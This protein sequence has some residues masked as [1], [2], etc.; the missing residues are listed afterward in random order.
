MIA[1][2]Q[3]ATWPIPLPAT[4]LAG[5][6]V[7]LELLN[8]SHIPELAAAGR[9]PSVWEFTTSRGVTD[10]GMQSY[11]ES[12][13]RDWERGAAVPFAVRQNSSGNIVGC[14]RV[15]E[16]NRR[17]RHGTVGSWYAPEAWRTGANLEAKLLVLDYAF[18]ELGC[19]RVE[20]H[21]DTRNLRSRTS[22]E[23]V[24]AVLE[25]VLRAHQITRDDG[26]RDSAIYSILR[27]EWEAVRAGIDARLERYRG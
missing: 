22:L 24:G 14:T 10:A 21:T 6:L 20:F 27:T 3:P 4:T 25:G 7:S 26:L 23:R 13:V 16:L 5:K 18:A 19:V 1:T 2:L 9:E 17:H 8:S 11:V 12:Q 15:K